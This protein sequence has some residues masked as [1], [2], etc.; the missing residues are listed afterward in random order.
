M[1]DLPLHL[2]DQLSFIHILGIASANLAP[3]ILWM[4]TPSFF[5][6]ISSRLHVSQF[7]KSVL[8]FLCSFSGFI[9]CP[10]V[11]I[12]SDNSTFKWERRRIYIVSALF[13]MIFGLILLINCD[14]IGIYFNPLNPIPTQQFI[15]F[16]SYLILV[17][18]GN[19][20][21]TPARSICTDVTPLSQQNLMANICSVFGGLGGLLI[22]ILG[23][24]K[25]HK[26]TNLNQ[27]QF[28]LLTST[29][30]CV[31]SILITIIVT[32]EEPLLVKSHKIHLFDLLYDAFVKMSKPMISSLPSFVLAT[33]AYFQYSFQFSHFIAKDIFH[34]DNSDMTRTDLVKKYND[35]ISWAM[36]CGAMKYASQ[37]F[38]GFV[39][40]RFSEVFGFKLTS[41]FGYLL[42]SIG[43]F[44]FFFVNSRYV[45][46]FIPVLLGIGYGT[47]MSVPYAI[48]AINA[49]MRNQEV[50]VYF[51]ILILFSVIGEQCSNFGIGVGLGH[52]FPD[53]PR[54]M[55]AVSS[56]F[57]V[58][59]AFSSFWIVENKI[60]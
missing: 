55:I 51:G 32:P 38:Y 50:G 8:L 28:I 35:G 27:E 23:G 4:I 49:K 60:E 12:Y 11:G 56:I 37:F 14:E 47:C 9:V 43:L 59:A 17:T 34:G 22:D 41:F 7:W 29:I 57:G 42:M 3:S 1:V 18:A 21:Q 10:I 48:A 6:P 53:N 52:I 16:I 54:M 36:F 31:L 26:Y 25:L 24:L 19:V 58:L 20:M 15:F 44:L 5:G 45:Y 46:L 39:C 13:L 30:L 40:H 2:R 33:L